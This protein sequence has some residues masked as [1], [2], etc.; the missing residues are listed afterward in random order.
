M[1]HEG[2]D[3][4][5]DYDGSSKACNGNIAHAPRASGLPGHTKFKKAT[6]TVTARD[7]VLYTTI[8]KGKPRGLFGIGFE[9]SFINAIR[10]LITP[11]PFTDGY[12]D[13]FQKP[14][15]QIQFS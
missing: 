6:H 12:F 1:Q 7:N 2:Y 10:S 8:C 14:S 9:E 5:T 4:V 15:V 3:P 13:V 11:R